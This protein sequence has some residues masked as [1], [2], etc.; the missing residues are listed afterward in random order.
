MTA[1]DNEQYQD[2][3]DQYNV[4]SHEDKHGRFELNTMD[5]GRIITAHDAMV[6]TAYEIRSATC[7]APS[8]RCSHACLNS[9]ND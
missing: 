5:A 7:G 6:A 8:A 3:D 9:R 4:W 2:I 1:A